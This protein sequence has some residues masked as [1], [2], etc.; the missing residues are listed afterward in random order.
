MVFTQKWS[1]C[2]CELSSTSKCLHP[3]RRQTRELSA[4]EQT[5]RGTRARPTGRQM[6]DF[7]LF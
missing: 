6:G 3:V 5:Y 2:Q 7:G 4:L 1:L